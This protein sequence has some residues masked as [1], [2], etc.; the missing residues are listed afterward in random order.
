MLNHLIKKRKR[1]ELILVRSKLKA[2]LELGFILVFFSVWYGFLIEDFTSF[3]S[4]KEEVVEKVSQQKFLI[5]FFLA[6]LFSIHRICLGVTTL[7]FGNKYIFSSLTYKI[8]H[9]NREICRY[10]QVENVRIRRIYDSNGADDYRLYVVHSGG[11]KLFIAESSD[12]PYI[13]GLASDIAG[14]CSSQVEQTD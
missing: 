1:A 6:P 11:R 4:I 7:V 2:L 14:A 3:E 12:S 10:D 8:S 5:L 13:R 9:N